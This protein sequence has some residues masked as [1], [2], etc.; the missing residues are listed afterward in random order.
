MSTVSMTDVTPAAVPAPDVPVLRLYVMRGAYLLIAIGMGMQV[1]PGIFQHG[2]LELF[3]GVSRS[4]LGAMTLLCLLGVRYPLAM[5]PI[6]FFEFAWK[7]IW[8][9]SFALPLWLGHRVDPNTW[10]SITACGFGV[11]VCLIAIP[12]PYAFKEYVLKAGDRWRSA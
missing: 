9:L 2:D 7:S 8:L 3:H 11:V 12:W 1:W 6:L 5:L 4:M 10:D